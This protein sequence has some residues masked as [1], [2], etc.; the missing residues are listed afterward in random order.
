MNSFISNNFRVLLQN[1][2]SIVLFYDPKLMFLLSCYF[3]FRK[4]KF[5]TFPNHRR[6][7]ICVCM[8]THTHTHTHTLLKARPQITFNHKFTG[9]IIYQKKF[10][11]WHF[12]LYYFVKTQ[13]K[14][15]IPFK[16]IHTSKIEETLDLNFSYFRG[17]IIPCQALDL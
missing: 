15:T 5:L 14:T 9:I 6:H 17:T 13:E 2:Y 3:N 11:K 10:V 4:T 1:Y 12:I 16:N 8:Y 7:H